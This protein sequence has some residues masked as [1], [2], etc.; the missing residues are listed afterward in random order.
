[1][2]FLACLV[3]PFAYLSLPI[4]IAAWFTPMG[5]YYLRVGLYIA[6]L[7]VVGT[8]SG[9]VALGMAV[10]GRRY[11]VNSVVAFS[12]YY[13]ASR[14]LGITIELEGEEYLETR[15][16]VMVGNHQSMFDILWLGRYVTISITMGYFAHRHTQH[17]RCADIDR[18]IGHIEHGASV[19]LRII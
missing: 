12:F 2:S 10:A 1:M 16:A 17:Q 5:R 14:V 15:P 11:D 7:S 13:L 4:I 6:C 19:A 8:T 9:F 3:K 18:I